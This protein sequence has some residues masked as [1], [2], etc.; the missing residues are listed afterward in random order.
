M[1]SKVIIPL[2][3]TLIVS[4]SLGIVKGYERLNPKEGLSAM[5]LNN[6]EALS[7]DE[8]GY[9]KVATRTSSSCTINVG[10]DG[11]VK[12]LG[13][14]ILTADGSGNI[15]IEGQVSCSGEGSVLCQPVECVDLYTAL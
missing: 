11:K 3:T 5:A 14:T 7:Q 1:K 15:T 9:Y 12:L 6:I 8:N 10:A 13:G 2:V 4:V